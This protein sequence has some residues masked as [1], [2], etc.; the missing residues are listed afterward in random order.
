MVSGNVFQVPDRY[1]IVDSIGVGSYG[2]VCM[3]LNYGSSRMVAIKKMEDVFEHPMKAL[4]TLREMRI[5]RHLSNENVLTILD[6]FVDRE[7]F[8]NVYLVAEAMDTDLLALIQSENYAIGDHSRFFLY[9]ILR[10]MKYIHSAGV[11]HRDIKPRNVL[12][13]KDSNVK[14]ADF[15]LARVL[16]THGHS[17]EFP[18]E[19]LTDYVCTRWYRAPEVLYGSEIYD[20]AVDM[21]SVGC[22]TVEIF[23]AKALFRGHDTENQLERIIEVVGTPSER[24][25]AKMPFETCREFFRRLPQRPK[26]DFI[27]YFNTIPPDVVDF[28]EATLQFK[29]GA[30]CTAAMAL[31]HGCV[32]HYHDPC[33]EPVRT[34]L[35]LEDFSFEYEPELTERDI[36]LELTR[37]MLMHQMHH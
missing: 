3:A 32:A 5:M 21:W 25:I 29:P 19:E 23:T 33:D 31:A 15:G 13:N 34:L 18:C 4:R 22:V 16:L 28:V 6:A 35:D 12:V 26:R 30:R 2:A 7:E 20:F 27:E 37:E 17:R 24:E 36:R 14:I 11:V 10:G 9:A 8:S 1:S